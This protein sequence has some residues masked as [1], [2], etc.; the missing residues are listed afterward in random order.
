MRIQSNPVDC[1]VLLASCK[2]LYCDVAK[3]IVKGACGPVLIYV[4]KSKLKEKE[5]EERVR[6]RNG[7]TPTETSTS[8]QWSIALDNIPD[9][10]VETTN[11]SSIT[12]EVFL[13]YAKHFVELLPTDH[14]TVI[15]FWMG[16]Q[17][18]GTNMC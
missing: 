14:E 7:K 15:L 3:G 11:S 13:T 16:I 8:L 17:A 9:V 18:T 12:Q 1:C 5:A 2:G 6:Q 4:D 10:K